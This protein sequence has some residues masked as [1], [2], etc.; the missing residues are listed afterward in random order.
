MII[1][2]NIISV[3]I[4]SSVYTSALASSHIARPTWNF[5]NPNWTT[6]IEANTITLRNATDLNLTIPIKLD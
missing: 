5:G 4:I 6:S 1:S 2:V 3:K